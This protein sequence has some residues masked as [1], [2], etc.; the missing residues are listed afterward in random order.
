[1][2]VRKAALRPVPS[3]ATVEDRWVHTMEQALDDDEERLQ[4]ALDR[5]FRDLDSRQPAVA[6]YVSNLLAQ[7]T[8]ELAQAVGYFLSVTVFLAFRE[9][10]PTR[11]EVATDDDIAMAEATLDA[12]EE[13]RVDDPEEA[14]ETDDIVAMGQPAIVA[15]VQHHVEQALEQGGEE[16]DVAAIEKVY[17]GILIE[18]ITLSHAVL[19]PEGTS[20]KKAFLA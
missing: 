14:L 17:R 16:V 3:Y 15:F 11:L 6:Q 10:F 4:E 18:I 13:L 12:D 20:P 9:A 5:G 19:A 1:M 7:V 2:F 8:D